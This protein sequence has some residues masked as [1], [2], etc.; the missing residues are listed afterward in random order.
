MKSRSFY[1][2]CSFF[3]KFCKF[4][5]PSCFDYKIILSSD[6]EMFNYIFSLR[7]SLF[8]FLIMQNDQFSSRKKKELHLPF[9]LIFKFWYLSFICS[10]V[11]WCQLAI[12][13]ITFWILNFSP[14]GKFF[15]Y[16]NLK[17]LEGD[18]DILKNWWDNFFTI[19]FTDALF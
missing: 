8:F 2:F 7:I 18:K 16:G 4:Y 10:K 6:K 9:L 14:L 1:V 13:H 12:S 17:I 19:Q 5:S 3:W 11:H 15:L